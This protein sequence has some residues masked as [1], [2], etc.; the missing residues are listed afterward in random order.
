MCSDEVSH[1]EQIIEKFDWN[2]L[3]AQR[4]L[5]ECVQMKLVLYLTKLLVLLILK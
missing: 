4:L 1:H 2:D 3:R 5:V